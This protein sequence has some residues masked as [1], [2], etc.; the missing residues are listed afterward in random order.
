MPRAKQ[1]TPELRDRVLQVAIAMLDERGV[2]G[3]TARN[4]AEGAETSVPAV[5]E[6]F[7][8]KAGLVR[9]MFFEGFG[10]LRHRFDALPESEDPRTDLLD[11]IDAYRTFV[12]GNPVLAAVMF[13]RPFAD[14]N[15]GPAEV[16][17][18][19]SVRRFVV[20]R[21]RRGIDAGLLAGDETDIAH[22]LLAL[23]QGL[24]AQEN[25]GWLGSSA[26]S[27]DRRWS[28]AFRALI[29]GLGPKA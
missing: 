18:T 6:L 7:G 24:A 19:G 28:L 17:K 21:V 5:Y 15:P 14:F 13:S 23:A 1:R 29:A 2:A 8:D 20:D 9:E 4:V 26:A 10:Q 22:A 3:F 27:V 25:A 16:R 11:V 12:R